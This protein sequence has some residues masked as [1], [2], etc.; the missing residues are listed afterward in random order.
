MKVFHWSAV[1]PEN[2]SPVAILFGILPISDGTFILLAR[3]CMISKC[4]VVNRFSSIHNWVTIHLAIPKNR[5]CIGSTI[6][7]FVGS[8]YG[9]RYVSETFVRWSEIYRLPYFDPTKFL[10]VDPMHCLFLGIA[11]WIVTRLWIEE[12]Q[13][14]TKHLEIMQEQ[15]NKIKVPSNIGRIPNKIATGDGFSGFTAKIGRPHV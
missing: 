8:K 3:S 9:S 2:P 7:N 4:F 14:T 1:N 11:K 5:Q 6:R 15:A 10:I 13:L 12:N